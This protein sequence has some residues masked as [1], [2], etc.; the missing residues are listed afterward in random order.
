MKAAKSDLIQL[1]VLPAPKAAAA[2]AKEEAKDKKEAAPAAP[3]KTGITPYELCGGTGDELVLALVGGSDGAVLAVT[4]D[5]YLGQD[6]G[7]GKR[8]GLQ[9]FL[10]NS[11]VSILA[12]PGVTA[13]EVQAALIGFCESQQELLCHSGRAHGATKR[14]TMWPIS[15]ICMTPPTPPCTTPGWRCS[16]PAPSSPAYFPP[17]GAM[18]GIYA[19]SDNERGVHKAPANE[20]VRGC[21]GLSC[22]YNTGEQDILNPLGVNLDP[23]FPRAGASVCG[24]PAPSAPTACGSTS[25]Y[26][27]CSSMWKSPS[28][29]TP[30]GWSLSPTA[31]H[32]GAGVTRT[33]ETFLATCWRDGALAGSQPGPGLLRGVRTHHHDPG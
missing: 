2:P 24:A 21:T 33:I 20:V 14:P 3:A 32:C 22:N 28:K 7:P 15:G 9:A 31:R 10:E 5:A 29:T 13:P 19:R 8:T 23:V 30:T 25:T 26:A 16:T 17:S 1:E 27:A 12:I 6:N 4:P 11:T 18:A